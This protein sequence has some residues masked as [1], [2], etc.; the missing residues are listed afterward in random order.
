MPE[1]DDECTFHTKADQIKFQTQ[2]NGDMI[3]INNLDLSQAQAS[4]FAWLVNN[5][6]NAELEFCVKVKP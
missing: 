3:I 5:D 6:N 4:S 1:I 2:T